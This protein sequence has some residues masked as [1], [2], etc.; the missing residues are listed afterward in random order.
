MILLF[1][2]RP[3]RLRSGAAAAFHVDGDTKTTKRDR[4]RRDRSTGTPVPVRAG[5]RGAV[6]R[7]SSRK[8]VCLLRRA[9]RAESRKIFFAFS[10]HELRVENDGWSHCGKCHHHSRRG[11]LDRYTVHCS[12]LRECGWLLAAGCCECWLAAF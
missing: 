7:V 8:T 9:T 6:F 3:R 5:S 2:P 11:D 12:M 10:A 1:R 4:R